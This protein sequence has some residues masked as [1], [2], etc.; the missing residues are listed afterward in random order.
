M[1][2]ETDF[3]KM[4]ICDAIKKDTAGIE[5]HKGA[6]ERI[7]CDEPVCLLKHKER[8]EETGYIDGILRYICPVSEEMTNLIREKERFQEKSTL[9]YSIIAESQGQPLF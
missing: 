3:N 1:K 8:L 2:E 9:D 7:L 6:Y 4:K 5:L